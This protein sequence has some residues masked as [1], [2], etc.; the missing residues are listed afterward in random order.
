M[1]DFLSQ[2][3]KDK[4]EH[5]THSEQSPKLVVEAEHKDKIIEEDGAINKEQKDNN[6][7]IELVEHE[8]V[9]D[10]KYNKRKIV[11][12]ISVATTVICLSIIILFVIKFANL[13]TVKSFTGTS[14]N[15]AK[16]W[17]LKNKI[18]IEQESEFNLEYNEDMIFFQDKESGKKISKGSILKVKVSKGANPD[19]RIELPDFSTMNLAEV[20]DWI[21]KNKTTNISII[22]EFNNDTQKNK[23]IKKEFKKDIV[24]ES[25][26]TRKDGINIYISK[27]PEVF[28]KNIAVPNFKDKSRAEVETWRATNDIQVQYTESGSS[29]TLEGMVIS[30]DIEANTKIA[31]QD[32]INIVI[33]KGKGVTVPSFN[34]ISREEAATSIDGLQI[35]VSMKY[36]LSVE[37]GKLISQSVKNGVTLY[38]ED[39]K[40]QVVYSEGKPYIE[41]LNGRTEKEIA[42]YFY[43]YASKGA[44]ISYNVKYVDSSQKKGT[45]VWTSKME[46]FIGMNDSIEIHVSKGNIQND[47]NTKEDTI[48]DIGNVI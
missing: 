1:S 34:N 48:N 31:K 10:S 14:I 36:S 47:N 16:T 27:G 28:E 17:G 8:T 11:L 29:E 42:P 9:I 44:N 6:R 4:Y 2:F 43:N 19:E 32:I 38:G 39:K 20:Q 33:S 23:F 24:N 30:Q 13:V 15:D 5:R 12:Y 46:E 7:A 40:V 35:S 45:I 22:T 37:Y 26:F 41:D 25:N 21:S 3:E 18:E